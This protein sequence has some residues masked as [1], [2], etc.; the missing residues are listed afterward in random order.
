MNSRLLTVAIVTGS[1]PRWV[2][3]LLAMFESA[4]HPDMIFLA[5][6]VFRYLRLVVHMISFW[7]LYKPTNRR[8][9]GQ[10]TEEDV[11]VIIP[12]VDPSN[13]DFAST[14]ASVL[15][16]Q[17]LKVLIVTVEGEGR[18]QT[19][20]KMADNLQDH[21]PNV[22]I[23]VSA[24]RVASKRA[25]VAHAIPLVTTALTVLCD[26]HVWW[27][28][29][30]FLRTAAAPFEDSYVGGVGTNKRVVRNKTGFGWTSFFNIL[31]ALYLERHN[32]EIRATNAVDGGVFVISGR[33]AVY[34][35]DILQHQKFLRGF[36]NERFFF[37]KFGPLNADDDNFI[38][39]WLVTNG[40]TVKIQYGED[41]RIETTLGEWPKFPSQCLRWSRTTWR[42]NTASLLTDRTVWRRQ[43]WCVYAVYLTSLVNFALFYDGALL[44]TLTRTSFYQ[45]NTNLLLALGGWIF[46]T[47]MVKT[48]PYFL[49]QPADLIY[50][51]GCLA[52]CYL[53]GF[54]KLYAMLTFWVTAWGGRDLDSINRHAAADD[55]DDDDDNDEDDDSD[56]GSYD[57]SYYTAS[58]GGGVSDDDDSSSSSS[59]SSH[60]ICT[61]GDC[62]RDD[63]SETDDLSSPT[64]LQRYNEQLNSPFVA[65]RQLPSTVSTPWGPVTATK[66]YFKSANLRADLRPGLAKNIARAALA[67][68]KYRL[69]RPASPVVES[70]EPRINMPPR[71]MSTPQAS[72]SPAKEHY[73]AA[74][75][76]RA[77]ECRRLHQTHGRVTRSAAACAL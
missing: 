64:L 46:L 19:A 17:P 6:F 4:R 77:E 7:F 53:H 57:S 69:T 8:A 75:W 33:T 10:Y 12:T 65:A 16:N 72:P 66:L 49:R 9:N 36:V 60:H 45:T 20:Q 30:N 40:W 34:R 1:Q 67:N 59:S 23:H 42:S 2:T 11:S 28:S 27:P 71:S 31:G 76:V 38:C 61:C 62:G 3:F 44:Y 13:P 39:R 14:L 22:V 35:T 51:P 21:Y 52:F 24:T 55:D 41:A 58:D 56:T 47:K 26:D 15:E 70:F 54:I 32:F 5:L 73:T 63:S 68:R 43:P 37:G 48:L 25:Q 74:E 50:L 18:V 29:K